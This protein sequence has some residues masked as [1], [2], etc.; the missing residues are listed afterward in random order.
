MSR[1]KLFAKYVFPSVL[2]FALSGVY[3]I[4]DGYFV[5]QSMGDTGLSAINIAFPIVSLIQ[6]SGTGIGMGGAVLWAVKR[7]TESPES[8]GKYVRATLLLL[9]LASAAS[10][11]GLFFLTGPVLRLF[12]AQ[13]KIFVFGKEYLD[14]IVLGAAFQICRQFS[15]IILDK[16]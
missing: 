11:T 1:Y 15:F 2:A 7:E 13:G 12:G 9:L 8:A 4:V 10:T 14:V 5:G 16:L 3:T 6:S